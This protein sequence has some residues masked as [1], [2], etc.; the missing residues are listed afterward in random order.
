MIALFDFI[1]TY[2]P[3]CG[4]RLF[5]ERPPHDAIRDYREAREPHTCPACGLRFQFCDTAD[6]VRAAQNENA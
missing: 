2:C 5:P 3:S 1:P 6:L 4:K